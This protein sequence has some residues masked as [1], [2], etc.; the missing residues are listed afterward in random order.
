VDM[1]TQERLQVDPKYVR[2]EY[3]RLVNEFIDQY[4]R[5]CSEMKVEYVPTHTNVPYDAMLTQY[6]GKRMRAR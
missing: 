6:L 1:E 4:R 2:Q 5:D 3:L